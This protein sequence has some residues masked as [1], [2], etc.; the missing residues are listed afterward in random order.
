M[1]IA[2]ASLNFVACLSKNPYAIIC[3]PY[4]TCQL[5]CFLPD[6]DKIQNLSSN[7]LRPLYGPSV[8]SVF[9]KELS[10]YHERPS[11]KSV[12]SVFEK[13]Y[14]RSKKHLRSK[15]NKTSCIAFRCIVLARPSVQRQSMCEQV[16]VWFPKK[17]GT[18]G[19]IVWSA[20]EHFQ[21]IRRDN[22]QRQWRCLAGGTPQ[23]TAYR[24]VT[25]APLTH[26]GAP[27]QARQGI[28]RRWI[29][30]LSQERKCPRLWNHTFAVH[31][32]Q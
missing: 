5:R 25:G 32:N 30:H 23:K 14:P 6:T 22:R 31:N 4:G 10:V 11:V 7:S 27:M 26:G 2:R 15:K 16:V 29:R 28:Y 20:A 24:V 1:S 8:K 3:R 18:A 19:V 13:N 12:K 17:Q 21:S 9:R